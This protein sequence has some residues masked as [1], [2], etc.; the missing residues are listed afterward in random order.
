MK[1]YKINNLNNWSRTE[2]DISDKNIQEILD[3]KQFTDLE[4]LY[5]YNNN[6]PKIL[7]NDEFISENK[8]NIINKLS[9]CRYK[10]MCLKYKEH[11]RQWLWIKVRLPKIEQ[12][13]HPDNLKGILDALGD[14][15]D[16]NELDEAI[17]NW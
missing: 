6:I 7:I 3:L 1:L 14:D 15:C 8:R 11:F 12:R 2:L 4:K 9:K 17:E 13:Y 5:C 16:E 10:I